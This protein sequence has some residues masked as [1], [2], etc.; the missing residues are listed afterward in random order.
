ML[1]DYDKFI[2]P[3]IRL[4]MIAV[5]VANLIAHRRKTPEQQIET[6]YGTWY[7]IAVIALGMLGFWTS[8][9][10]EFGVRS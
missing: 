5:G 1:A 9:V 8:L 2:T 4:A 6:A 7:S 10:V 3:L